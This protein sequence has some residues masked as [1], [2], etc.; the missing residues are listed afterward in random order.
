MELINQERTKQGLEPLAV[1][2][3]LTQAARK[4]TELLAAHKTVSHQLEGEPPLDIRF[5]NENLAVDQGGENT[6]VGKDVPSAHEGLMR[7]PVHHDNIVN[8]NYNAVGVG[9]IRSGGHLY[10]TEDFAHLSN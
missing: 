7:D 9:V 6:A 3:R 4:H 2:P 10:V 1:D 5:A 8:P